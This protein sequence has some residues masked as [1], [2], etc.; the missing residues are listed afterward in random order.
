MLHPVIHNL[1]LAAADEPVHVVVDDVRVRVGPSGDAGGWAVVI[2]ALPVIF[3]FWWLYVTLESKRSQRWV[4]PTCIIGMLVIFLILLMIKV[5]AP[6]LDPENETGF[7]TSIL[8]I[9]TIFVLLPLLVIFGRFSIDWS[10]ISRF[11]ITKNLKAH[12]FFSVIFVFFTISVLL[13]LLVI[14]WLFTV[15]RF[16]IPKKPKANI[17]NVKISNPSAT[18]NPSLTGQEGATIP[19]FLKRENGTIYFECGYCSQPMEIDASG[20]GMEIKC[21]ECGEPQKVPTS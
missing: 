12:P 19:K 16:F 11:S 5:F 8:F 13:P 7:S 10:P 18:A 4:Q 17:H 21:P 6:P 2:L 20:G 14:F 15:L 3:F 9:F 1:F